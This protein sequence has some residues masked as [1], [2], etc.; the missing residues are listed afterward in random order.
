VIAEEAEV[1]VRAARRRTH[2][3]R[4]YVRDELAPTLDD[5]VEVPIEGVA[6]PEIERAQRLFAKT[7]AP[8]L[9]QEPGRGPD[10]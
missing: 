4:D 8:S 6:N 7:L 1:C 5:V 3:A 9:D 2:Q 10:G